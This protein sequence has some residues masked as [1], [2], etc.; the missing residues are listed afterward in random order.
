MVDRK[1]GIVLDILDDRKKATLKDWLTKNKEQFCEVR[2]VSMDMWEP[3]INAVK[4]IIEGAET[5]ICFDRFHMASSFGKAVDTVRAIEHRTLS[6]DTQSPLT[7][8]KHDWLRTKAN[9]GYKDK[10]ALCS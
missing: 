4:E 3:F 5:M 7:K 1:K 8:T 6:Q 2:S 10:R 9:G